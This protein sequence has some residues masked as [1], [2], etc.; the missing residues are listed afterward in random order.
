MPRF[1]VSLL[2]AAATLLWFSPQTAA[3]QVEGITPA[4]TTVQRAPLDPRIERLKAEAATKVEA[5]AKLIQEI[6]DQVYSYG[7]LGMQEFETSKYLTGIL[8]KNGFTVTR[9]VAGM[10][11]AWVARWGNGKPVIS[12]GS[13]ID[14]IPQSNQAPATAYRQWQVPGAP[15]HGEG[16]NSGQAVNIELKHT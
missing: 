4:K 11:T 8:E 16:H 1:R 5:R 2:C 3:A 15:G 9:N 10:P 13:D 12:L 14:G 6:I 7:E